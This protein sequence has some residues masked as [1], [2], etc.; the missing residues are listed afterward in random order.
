MAVIGKVE[1]TKTKNFTS[2]FHLPLNS[3]YSNE[4]HLQI[5]NAGI[6]FILKHKRFD[7]LLS[8]S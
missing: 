2:T 4:V 6:N 1:K 3:N 7:K 8:N 5:L